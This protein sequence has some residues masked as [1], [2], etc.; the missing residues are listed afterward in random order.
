MTFHI[1]PRLLISRLWRSHIPISPVLHCCPS[2]VSQWACTRSLSV[3]ASHQQPL[4]R[5]QSDS[6]MF[7]WR[8][9]C[10]YEHASISCLPSSSVLLSLSI[11]PVSLSE[12][13]SSWPLFLSVSPPY[14]L[15]RVMHWNK[16]N[17]MFIHIVVLVFRNRG[18]VVRNNR[19][20]GKMHFNFMYVSLN[21]GL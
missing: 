6:Q 7:A 19:C 5:E 13:L 11:S 20:C 12:L 21:T 4:D 14:S 3:P 8:F 9:V 18:V 10:I 16:L 17:N 15:Y 2:T 1:C